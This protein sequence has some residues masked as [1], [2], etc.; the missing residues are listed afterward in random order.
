MMDISIQKLRNLCQDKLIKW[1]THALERL[2]ERNISL[3]QVR[4]AILNG[5][6]IEQYPNDRPFPSCL[7][8]GWMENNVPLHVVCGIGNDFLWIITSYYP[9]PEKW[10][11]DNKT[12]KDEPL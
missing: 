12:R 5:E 10:E 2:Q 8:V 7:V 3:D 1:T 11:N 4:N 6:I 9:N